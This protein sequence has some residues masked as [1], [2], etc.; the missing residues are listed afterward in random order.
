MFRLAP[1]CATALAWLSACSLVLEDPTPFQV[2]RPDADVDAE[3]DAAPDA[4]VPDAWVPPQRLVPDAAAPAVDPDAAPRPRPD[5]ALPDAAAPDAA[6]PD[7]CVPADA[8]TCNGADDDCDGRADEG[9]T[10][11]EVCNGR[12]D[13]CDGEID[14]ADP[15]L[16]ERCGPPAARGACGAG[17]FVCLRGALVC[18]AWLPAAGPALDCNM[19]DDDCDGVL[20]EAGEAVRPRSPDEQAVVDRCGENPAA[21]PAAECGADPR[22]VG[23]AEVHACVEPGCR[24]NCVDDAA[25]VVATCDDGCETVRPNDGASK[26][27]CRASCRAAVEEGL[28]DCFARCAR[29]FD[30]GATRWRCAGDDGGPACVALDCPAGTHADGQRCVAD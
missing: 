2:S 13:D 5:A 22:V 9:V 3:V 11:D 8:E 20:D 15:R 30:D 1:T 19:R 21:A 25:L 18:A 24:L 7:A 26:A 10:A 16:C 6:A 12:D 14:E 27:A 17:A 29:D 23:C 4:F 28:G